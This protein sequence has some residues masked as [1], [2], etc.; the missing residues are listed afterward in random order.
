MKTVIIFAI[1]M[2]N[3]LSI[4][5]F[6][7][8]NNPYIYLLTIGISTIGAFMV[9]AKTRPIKPFPPL[10]EIRL[11][12]EESIQLKTLERELRQASNLSGYYQSYEENFNA[13][14]TPIEEIEKPKKEKKRSD[15]IDFG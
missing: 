1:I 10:S 2:L 9:L 6:S 5:V 12:A 14:E 3:A 4:A 15:V 8:T 11:V 13:V 7:F